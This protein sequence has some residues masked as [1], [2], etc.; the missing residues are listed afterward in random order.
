MPGFISDPVAYEVQGSGPV[1]MLI[2]Q[3]LGTPLVEFPGGH[4]GFTT[5]AQD[6]ASV[7]GRTLG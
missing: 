1:L 3:R 7:L 5:D 6:F 2:G 4:A